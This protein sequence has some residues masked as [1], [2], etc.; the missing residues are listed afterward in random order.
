MFSFFARVFEEKV[1]PNLDQHAH[2]G[3][4]NTTSCFDYIIIIIII[5][6]HRLIARWGQPFTGSDSFM[7]VCLVRGGTSLVHF[8]HLIL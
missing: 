7:P 8:V 2:D 3:G 5:I 4:E 1:R 6:S